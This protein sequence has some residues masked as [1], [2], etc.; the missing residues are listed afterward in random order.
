MDCFIILILSCF[1]YFLDNSPLSDVIFTHIFSMPMAYPFIHWCVFHRAEVFNL[2]KSNLSSIY[3]VD[4]AFDV[5]SGKSSLN[6]RSF[7]YSPMI[8]SESVTVLCLHL[9]L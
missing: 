6:L 5:V 7:R 1:L 8:S 9:D 2:M 4:Y 3:F